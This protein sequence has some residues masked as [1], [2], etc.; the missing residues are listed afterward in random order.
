M[1]ADINSMPLALCV[2]S[3]LD[4]ATV[5]VTLLLPLLAPTQK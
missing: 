2:G 3:G 1:A 5:P 4:C